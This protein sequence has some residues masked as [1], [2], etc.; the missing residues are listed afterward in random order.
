M[1]VVNPIIAGL[2]ATQEKGLGHFAIIYG[3][4]EAASFGVKYIGNQ[5]Q[6][7]VGQRP[8]YPD[9]YEGMPSGH[10][11]SAWSGASYV[12]AFSPDYAYLVVPLYATSIATGYSRIT[13]Q[14]H[15]TGQVVVGALIAEILTFANSKLRWSENYQPKFTFSYG[16]QQSRVEFFMRF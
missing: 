10:T 14:Q 3:Q 15:S 1:Q 4:I 9:N 8:G 16:D 2:T 6:W 13:S 12:R 7:G 11:A 5:I